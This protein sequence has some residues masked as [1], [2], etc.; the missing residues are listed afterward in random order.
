MKIRTLVSFNSINA[1]EIV[2]AALN[3]DKNRAMCF[4]SFDQPCYFYTGQFEIIGDEKEK[5][6]VLS[7][8]DFLGQEVK[9]L[10]FK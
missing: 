5:A 4:D 8:R 3:K 6:I 1:N 10:E 9:S 7:L 2:D